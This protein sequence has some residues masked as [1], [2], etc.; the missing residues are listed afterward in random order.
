MPAQ[1]QL[2]GA[3]L[4]PDQFTFQLLDSEWNLVALV[5]NKGD[6]SIAFPHEMIAQEGRF[7]YLMRQMT[8]TLPGIESDT[9]VY[10]MI[11]DSS[12]DS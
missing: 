6:G 3:Q 2:I 7:V 10:A 4:Q 12:L 8:G 9:S 5:Q 11:V 1:T